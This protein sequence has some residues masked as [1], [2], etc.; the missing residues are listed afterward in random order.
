M[1]HRLLTEQNAKT[2][3]GAKFGVKTG[4][5]Y[6]RPGRTF[7]GG[8]TK[9]CGMGCLFTAGRGKMKPVQAGRIRKTKLFLSDRKAFDASL[10]RELRNLAKRA[11]KQ[12]MRAAARLDGTSDIG[13]A[14]QVC[15]MHPD[16]QFYDYTKIADRYERF[17]D[18]KLPSNWHL[19]FS[20][21]E[22]NESQCVDFLRRGGSVAAV[23]ETLPE[24][25]LGFPVI[26]GDAHDIRFLDREI[27][28]IA[29]GGFWVGLTAKG[30][31]KKDKTGFVIRER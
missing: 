6:L 22:E 5:V 27:S 13:H 12:N 9:G 7:C 16:L 26:D 21:S 23:F 24:T 4:I 31:A 8:M 19:T 10:N 14:E 1:N 2:I 15:Q 17:L 18:G 20:R 30:Q 29:K 11:A 28:G 3:K 25:Y